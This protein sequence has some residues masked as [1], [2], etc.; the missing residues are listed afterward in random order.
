MVGL[1]DLEPVNPNL[2]GTSCCTTVLNCSPNVTLLHMTE[3][4]P[5]FLFCFVVFFLSFKT[6]LL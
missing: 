6:S 3:M 2:S 1:W 5:V 4:L